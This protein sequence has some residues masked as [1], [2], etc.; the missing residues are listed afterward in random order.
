MAVTECSKVDVE[1]VK[2][3]PNIT[4]KMY[5][6]KDKINFCLVAVTLHTV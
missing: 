3:I 1:C 5:L 6:Q 2:H 4:G